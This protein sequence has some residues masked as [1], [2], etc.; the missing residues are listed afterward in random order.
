MKAK[1]L[2][3]TQSLQKI[4]TNFTFQEALENLL[5]K[6][7]EPIIEKYFE[8]VLNQTASSQ[9]SDDPLDIDQA[10]KLI[11]RSKQTVYY[12]CCKNLIPFHKSES[13]LIFF[14]DELLNW[15]KSK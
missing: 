1:P 11:K 9:N 7:T 2:K 14:K 13:R 6:A 3:E 15:L 5:A 4:E 10:A 12:Y 8:R